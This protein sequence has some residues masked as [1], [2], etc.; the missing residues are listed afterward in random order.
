MQQRRLKVMYSSLSCWSLASVLLSLPVS[1][2]LCLW[3]LYYK[4]AYGE[5]RMTKKIDQELF[6]TVEHKGETHNTA[7]MAEEFYH[8]G[9]RL[10]ETFGRA[11]DMY[12]LMHV[13]LE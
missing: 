5:K 4:C 6:K 13:D 3:I 8:V 11:P 12:Q 7:T 2:V 1:L 9:T 10:P